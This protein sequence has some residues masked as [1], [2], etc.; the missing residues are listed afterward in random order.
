MYLPILAV[1][2]TSA[3]TLSVS[4]IAWHQLQCWTGCSMSS[5]PAVPKYNEDLHADIET[6]VKDSPKVKVHR[7]EWAKVR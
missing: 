3:I 1:T 4:Y 7:V 5:T 2:T 6:A